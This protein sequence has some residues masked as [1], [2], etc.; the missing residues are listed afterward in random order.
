MLHWITNDNKCVLTVIEKHYKEKIYNKKFDD[1]EI[2]FYKLISP[3]YD[4]NKNNDDYSILIYMGTIILW[5]ISVIRL[6]LKIYNNKITS[7]DE[8]FYSK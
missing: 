3:I 4:F 1:D 6:S 5:C 8:F 7:Y 2:F